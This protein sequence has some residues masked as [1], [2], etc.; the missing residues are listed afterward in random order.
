[1]TPTRPLRMEIERSPAL[2]QCI[3]GSESFESR[4]KEAMGASIHN[5][6]PA[7]LRTSPCITSQVGVRIRIVPVDVVY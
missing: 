4:I 5:N 6:S 2:G 3:N 7:L 1:M